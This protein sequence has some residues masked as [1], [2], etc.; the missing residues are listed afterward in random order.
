MAAAAAAPVAQQ[1]QQQCL[2]RLPGSIQLWRL[3]RCSA[4]PGRAV[5]VQVQD[6]QAGCL[7]A[8]LAALL[9][10]WQRGVLTCSCSAGSLMHKV[11]RKCV[12]KLWKALNMFSCVAAVHLMPLTCV[13]ML[14]CSWLFLGCCLTADT[15]MHENL[16]VRRRHPQLYNLHNICS[17]TTEEK[18]QTILLL[19]T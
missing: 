13:S 3:H 10:C 6:V 11:R 8:V 19:V 18:F 1:Q 4:C 16:V 15:E 17:N 2:H 14:S 5:Q 12:G 9:P 7:G